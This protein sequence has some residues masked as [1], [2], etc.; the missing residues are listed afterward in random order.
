MRAGYYE[1]LG[2]PQEIIQVGEVATPRP[3]PGEVL[4]RIRV[5][6]INPSD[7]KRATGWSGAPMAHA[8]VI[9]VNDGAGVIDAIGDD[10]P[11]TLIGQRVWVYEATLV[12]PKQGTAA[13]YCVVPVEYA[14][15]LPDNADFSFG[16]CLGV[17]AMTAHRAVFSEGPVDGK[18]VLVAGGAG[19]VG[20]FAVQFAAWR[21]AHVIATVGSEEKAA[22]ARDAGADAVFLY[23]DPDLAAKITA[24][25]A[26]G[27]SGGVDHVAEVHF[28]DNIALDAKVLK[29]NGS[30]SLYG[31]SSDTGEQPVVPMRDLLRKGINLRWVMVYA[32]PAGP[33][34][35]ALRDVERAIIEGGITPLVAARYPL[36]E[37]AKAMAEVGVG[38]TG[39]KVLIDID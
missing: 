38:G 32:L 7:L 26:A 19:S 25:A 39:G 31:S 28:R 34:A 4:V 36:D 14:V 30:V 17:P 21:G 29:T 8:R 13:Q 37:L 6:G 1:R 22:I 2:D 24:C 11:A 16:A 33:R 27:P 20:R 18:T 10:L 5:A 35:A 23:T 12:G 15:P 3:G 9:P